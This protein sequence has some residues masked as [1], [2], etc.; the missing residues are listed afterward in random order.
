MET[1]NQ[2]NATSVQLYHGTQIAF[3]LGNDVMVNLTD[4]AKAFPNKNLANILN[5]KEI[6]E[7]CDALSKIQ[8]CIFADLLTVRKGAPELGGGTWAH[9]KVALRVAQKLS[10][11]FAV[12]VDSKL[13]ELLTT[14]VATVS[15]D[16]EVIAQ[17]MSVLQRRLEANQQ[18]VQILQG[19]VDIQEQEIKTL[20]PKATYTD[21]VLQSTTT[22]T[23]TQVAH[24]LNMRSVF[25]LTG[26]LQKKGILYRQSGQWQPTAKVAGKHYF[27][28]RTAKYIQSDGTVG[29][30]ISTVVTELGRAWLHTML[31]NERRTA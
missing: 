17:A 22:Y 29:S 16:D 23:L 5:S 19:T 24:D 2:P 13:E 1:K 11:E 20:A 27:T 7:Y 12:W 4:V 18:R 14:G 9:Q 10:P 28:T 3:E 31:N 30:S 15:N 6:K 8:N 21:E 25:E 26:W